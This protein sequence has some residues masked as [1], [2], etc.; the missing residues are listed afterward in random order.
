[1]NEQQQIVYPKYMEWNG[2]FVVWPVVEMGDN[3]EIGL[4]ILPLFS[5]FHYSIVFVQQI[6]VSR[7]SVQLYI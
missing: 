4:A 6:I 3:F 1:M 2:Y 5:L 7:A